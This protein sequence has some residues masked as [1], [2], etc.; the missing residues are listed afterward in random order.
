LEDQ[1]FNSSSSLFIWFAGALQEKHWLVAY[2]YLSRHLIT[3]GFTSGKNYLKDD[4][5]PLPLS[6]SDK[7]NTNANANANNNNNNN[8]TVAAAAANST[9]SRNVRKWTL[10]ETEML[11]RACQKVWLLDIKFYFKN[12][13]TECSKYYSMVSE[14]GQK[15]S[16][17]PSST[18]KVELLPT[19]KTR[20]ET[21]QKPRRTNCDEESDPSLPKK[22]K[23]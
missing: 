12:F 20:T 5:K 6:L 7:M 2:I 18:F 10:E 3:V 15:C 9:R 14:H 1:R 4:G 22:T 21:W 17:T 23:W 13:H 11:K 19:S 8:N 16:T